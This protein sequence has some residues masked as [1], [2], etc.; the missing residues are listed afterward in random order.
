MRHKKNTQL[1]I[2]KCAICDKTFSNTS[3]YLDH[4]IEEQ[5]KKNKYLRQQLEKKF[6]FKVY[7]CRCGGIYIKPDDQWQSRKHCSKCGDYID[8]SQTDKR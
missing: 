1:S 4:K 3:E 5:T 6:G 8:L 2:L 7:S